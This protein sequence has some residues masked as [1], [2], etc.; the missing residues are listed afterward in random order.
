[1]FPNKA[2]T[3]EIGAPFT[4]ISVGGEGL[5][6]WIMLSNFFT[7]CETDF[8]F[9]IGREI[10]IFL[11]SLP[12]TEWSTLITTFP[13]VVSPALIISSSRP[14]EGFTRKS[15]VEDSSCSTRAL[16]FGRSR[17]D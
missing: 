7:R 11:E 1:M 8:C 2:A 13:S 16:L 9:N 6:G 4:L 10:P 15:S 3:Y 5:F 12:K 14:A 17:F